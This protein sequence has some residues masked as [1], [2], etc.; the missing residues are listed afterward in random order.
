[1]GTE[2]YRRTHKTGEVSVKDLRIVSGEEER[3]D[4][5]IYDVFA[6]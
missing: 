3:D 5:N 1:M 4:F 6:R 2:S